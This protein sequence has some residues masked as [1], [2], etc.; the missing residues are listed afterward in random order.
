M[1]E[2][3][4]TKYMTILSEMLM[5]SSI[6]LDEGFRL[7]KASACAVASAIVETMADK[8]ADKSMRRVRRPDTD[9][10]GLGRHRYAF[11]A[12]AETASASA[13]VDAIRDDRAP[14]KVAHDSG[15]QSEEQKNLSSWRLRFI[16]KAGSFIHPNQRKI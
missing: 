14:A 12:A 11:A 2:P 13:Q 9:E 10:C 8:M 15:V 3:G 6:L 1:I 4:L 16:F 5:L 7:R